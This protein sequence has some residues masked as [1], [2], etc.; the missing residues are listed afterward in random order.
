LA[1]GDNI[2]ARHVSRGGTSD[3]FEAEAPVTYA[4]PR[5]QMRLHLS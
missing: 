1:N 2:V 5:T 3:D 4:W